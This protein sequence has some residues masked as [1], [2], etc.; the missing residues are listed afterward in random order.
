MSGC[1]NVPE[2]IPVVIN[3]LD[4]PIVADIPGTAI[5][6]GSTSL[7]ATVLNTSGSFSYNWSPSSQ[8]TATATGLS[9]T[10]TTTYTVAVTPG[11]GCSILKTATV[12]VTTVSDD[13]YIKD[14]PSDD[15]TEPN[16]D[17]PWN[18]VDGTDI[19]VRNSP[20]TIISTSPTQRYTSEHQHESPVYSANWGSD[21][22][23]LPR[24]YVKIRNRGCTQVFGTLH[25]YFVDAN[26]NDIWNTSWQE[27]LCGDTDGDGSIDNG[28]SSCSLD[29]TLDPGQETVVEQVWN[30]LQLAPDPGTGQY[31]WCLLARVES[32][33]DP[34]NGENTGVSAAW[35][36]KASNQITQKNVMIVGGN[37]M[38]DCYYFNFGNPSGDNTV[39]KLEMIGLSDGYT[40]HHG[41]VAVDLGEDLYTLWQNAGAYGSGIKY[42]SDKYIHSFFYGGSLHSHTHNVDPDPNP[43]QIILTNDTAVLDSIPIHAE[44]IFPICTSF[45][46]YPYT[47]P[48]VPLEYSFRQF[49]TF[50]GSPM[51]FT[52]AMKFYVNKPDCQ[53][54]DAGEDQEI[55]AEDPAEFTASP[56]LDGAAYTWWEMESGKLVDNGY[57]IVVYPLETT[58]YEVEMKTPD[59]CISYDWITVTVDGGGRKSGV[60]PVKLGCYPNPA[61]DKVVFNYSLPGGTTQAQLVITTVQGAVVKSYNLL[62]DKK[63]IE[64]D[65]S[66]LSEGVYFYTLVIGNIPKKTEKLVILKPLTR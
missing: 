31:E 66:S 37:V 8:T 29:I 58:T 53:Q 54:V 12:E 59:G 63:T 25:L 46:F 48:G 32:T 15:G 24:I 2:E 1:S 30:Q 6:S 13:L 39:N 5:C 50:D 61:Y 56:K 47:L 57:N 45:N 11:T 19:W 43:Y 44:D 41:Y 35:N 16:P 26:S 33:S 60:Q 4:F 23:T 49:Q 17:D 9:P 7:T 42:G 36:A 28:E 27:I 34:I 38:H 20:A 62:T 3:S 14:T 40:G 55:Y 10:T 22:S 52:G 64:A 21:V 65:C 51:D 18:I